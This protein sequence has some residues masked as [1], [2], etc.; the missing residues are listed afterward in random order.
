VNE[1][2][3]ELI[4]SLV[5]SAFDK[6]EIKN[7]AATK[8]KKWGYS[9][10]DSEIEPGNV[11]LVGING[12]V[13]KGETWDPQTFEKKPMQFF[14]DLCE[15]KP[16]DQGS[17]RQV[18]TWFRQ[19]SYLPQAS[20]ERMGQVNYCFFRSPKEGDIT[21][22][23]LAL[24][25]PIFQQLLGFAEPTHLICFLS[26]RITK[27]IQES[28]GFTTLNSMRITYPCGR[29]QCVF[30]AFKGILRVSTA[31]IPI[32]FL[33]HPALPLTNDTR[34]SAWDFCFA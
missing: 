4:R 2:Q 24:C 14:M 6:S 21:N 16:K 5:Q 17:F 23:D 33:P 10:C 34:K 30:N 1:Q 15:L 9:I 22:A 27:R 11:L 28:S 3:F 12:G 29:S 19:Y 26:G 18:G 7:R 32:S 31:D 8:G 13:A 20:L 25:E